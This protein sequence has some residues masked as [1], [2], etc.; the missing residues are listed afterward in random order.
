M[1]DN[2]E[3]RQEGTDDHTGDSGDLQLGRDIYGR[4]AHFPGVSSVGSHIVRR[5]A[6]FNAG[7]SSLG[8]RLYRRWAGAGSGFSWPDMEWLHAYRGGQ[9]TA[10]SS[11]PQRTPLSARTISYPSLESSTAPILRSTEDAPAQIDPTASKTPPPTGALDSGMTPQ[12][13][14][15]IVSS[16]V[17]KQNLPLVYEAGLT[18]AVDV[19]RKIETNSSI[20][21]QQGKQPLKADANA[22]LTAHSKSPVYVGRAILQ[23]S[24]ARGRT[25]AKPNVSGPST[26]SG[27]L[28]AG[29]DLHRLNRQQSSG[30]ES[31]KL[32][33]K[34]NADQSSNGQPGQPIHL[35][36]AI[37][38]MS[39]DT[40]PDVDAAPIV[41]G[42]ANSAG[43][44]V[45]A[46]ITQT[47]S[48]PVRALRSTARSSIVPGK[49]AVHRRQTEESLYSAESFSEHLVHPE[50]GKSSQ[51]LSSD[52]TRADRNTQAIRG[53]A[54]PT[55]EGP[56]SPEKQA[57]QSPLSAQ[58]S[59]HLFPAPELLPKE[60]ILHAIEQRPATRVDTVH[61][62]QAKT[63][64]RSESGPD[65][66][67]SMGSSSVP[68]APAISS[69]TQSSTVASASDA[70]RQDVS[71]PAT[72]P[73]SQT[74][75]RGLPATRDLNLA[76]NRP[77][78]VF[79]SLALPGATTPFTPGAQNF[80]ANVLQR[81]R[82]SLITRVVDA[83]IG[84]NPD[85]TVVQPASA[86]SSS[87]NQVNVA[88][89]RA[90]ENDGERESAPH[91]P[92]HLASS[93]S[94]SPARSQP[95]TGIDAVGDVPLQSGL[96]AAGAAPEIVIQ[97]VIQRESD[98]TV[99][100]FEGRAPVVERS[101]TFDGSPLQT[102]R[103]PDET[104]G[105]APTA[106]AHG[107]P[108]AA[109]QHLDRSAIEV[110]STPE[111]PPRVP[112]ANNRHMNVPSVM[113]SRSRPQERATSPSSTT[114]VG[115]SS[116]LPSVRT[117]K[118]EHDSPHTG[119][120]VGS[121][122]FPSVHGAPVLHNM[123]HRSYLDTVQDRAIQL[124]PPALSPFRN[125]SLIHRASQI[126][127]G[128][129]RSPATAA[130]GSYFLARQSDGS[131]APSAIPAAVP[132]PTASSSTYQA[133]N[134]SQSSKNVDVGQ[135]ANRV[136][137][138]L[139][140]RLASER[141]RRGL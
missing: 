81:H 21:R 66:G 19:E 123:V 58:P 85:R 88:T 65:A 116:I 140:R 32:L 41:A 27:A 49:T 97:P 36:R 76:P 28:P 94:S 99:P 96:E 118:Q 50:A 69:T 104:A 40:K 70:R 89:A 31:T 137:D 67:A 75:L 98:S 77:A 16:Q 108:Q 112:I 79:R 132:L 139:V 71:S 105:S 30:M 48:M 100:R 101:G 9:A 95:L 35:A 86:V 80:G 92:S 56:Q 102:H 111:Q 129:Q 10:T 23:R 141:Q 25:D 135:L 68:L 107:R 14:H 124:R 39:N 115:P 60:G 44:H 6:Q 122:F 53:A 103:I 62:A 125:V 51:E 43:T 29:A 93:A 34:G 2:S 78:P 3:R 24:T 121:S 7:S 42:P 5:I 119:A 26:T 57:S 117:T 131:P 54:Q 46:P 13:Q 61:L 82:E 133:G 55:I 90:G 120:H 47:A 45:G 110:P 84:H 126:T 1:P 33:S 20:E 136:Y 128:L 11:S 74:A 37:P 17:D 106:H 134:A 52:S 109:L 18:P 15:P 12:E 22:S 72:S 8:Q 63:V 87:E 83:S 59:N 114:H 64:S 4:H 113:V 73:E 91:S 38:Q 127:D 130:S 138:L